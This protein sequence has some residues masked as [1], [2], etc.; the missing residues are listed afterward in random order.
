MQRTEILNQHMF[1][2]LR[3]P[4]ST[5]ALICSNPADLRLHGRVLNPAAQRIAKVFCVIIGP[6]AQHG[7][8]LVDL[9]S[10]SLVKLYDFKNMQTVPFSNPAPTITAAGLIH[11]IL[12]AH[13]GRA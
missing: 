4:V 8:D 2:W 13:A 12:V 7:A 1:F 3:F 11:V 10:P 9:L 6:F 5:F